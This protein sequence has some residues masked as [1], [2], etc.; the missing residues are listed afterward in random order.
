MTEHIFIVP[1]EVHVN[2]NLPGAASDSG[3]A[4]AFALIDVTLSQH[5]WSEELHYQVQYPDDELGQRAQKVGDIL[6]Q[7]VGEVT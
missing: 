6:V 1:V 2:A 7:V 5:E 3:R 4:A